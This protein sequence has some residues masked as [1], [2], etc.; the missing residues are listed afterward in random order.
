MPFSSEEI[1]LA[2]VGEP[3]GHLLGRH[4]NLLKGNFQKKIIWW[5]QI[6]KWKWR[7]T[8]I[9]FLLIKGESHTDFITGSEEKIKKKQK[10]LRGKWFELQMKA[11]LFFSTTG[12][13]VS[14]NSLE[15][16]RLYFDLYKNSKAIKG[17]EPMLFLTVHSFHWNMHSISIK[18][19]LQ[20]KLN[21][22]N[23]WYRHYVLWGSSIKSHWIMNE[24]EQD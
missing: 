10:F 15:Q 24:W 11:K 2:L 16:D 4:P 8:K 9:L 22:K 6:W 17:Q 12:R 5:M 3:T 14:E 19:I 1:Y 13:K 20:T 21:R 7:H 23:L 18:F